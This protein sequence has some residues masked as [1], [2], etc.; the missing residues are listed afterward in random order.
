VRVKFG[1]LT[2]KSAA[3]VF[4]LVRHCKTRWNLDGRIQG[5]TDI[6]LCEEG[7]REA[8]EKLPA[9]AKLGLRWVASSP[10]LRGRQTAE[11]YAKGLGIPLIVRE[12]LREMDLGDWEGKRSKDLLAEEGSGYGRWLSDPSSFPLPPGS[13]ESVWD[14]KDRITRAVVELLLH[15]PEGPF[16]L[17]LH[18]YVRSLLHCAL[19]GLP[20]RFFASWIIEHTDP[21]RVD[22]SEVARLYPAGHDGG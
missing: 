17:V 8:Q 19:L 9:L 1:P 21:Y 2:E 3:P 10:L 15:G 14:A 7:L 11:I 5:L 20:L 13:G 4:F 18:K 16:L 22:A 6:P 12:D